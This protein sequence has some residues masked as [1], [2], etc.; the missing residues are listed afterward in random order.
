MFVGYKKFQFKRNYPDQGGIHYTLS[1][2]LTV[3]TNLAVCSANEN[4]LFLSMKSSETYSSY[5]N[6]RLAFRHCPIL[7]LQ[8]FILW[9][10]GDRK[11]LPRRDNQSIGY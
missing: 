10:A 11:G 1:V 7:N 4:F 8:L 2:K 6:I 5:M 3:S 9:M